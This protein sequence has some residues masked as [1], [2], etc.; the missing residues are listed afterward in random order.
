MINLNWNPIVFYKLYG[1]FGIQKADR[2]LYLDCDV[3][4]DDDLTDFY[5][6]DLGGYYGAVIEDVGME[7]VIPDYE[8]HLKRLM[9]KK[10][11]YFNGGVMLLNLKKIQ[12]EMCLQHMIDRFERYADLMPF[13]EQ[14]LLNM[15][16]NGR[17]CY[18]DSRY[19][20]MA[21]DFRYRRQIGKDRDVAIYHYTTNKPWT[22]WQNT[23]R[24][25]YGW[26]V[27]KYLQY[28]RL[29]ETKQLFLQVRRQNRGIGRRILWWLKGRM[30]YNPY[31]IY[32]GECA[33]AGFGSLFMTKGL[34]EKLEN[35][36][37]ELLCQKQFGSFFHALA[38]KGTCGAKAYFE[39]HKIR[40]IAVYGIGRVY[41]AV[42]GELAESADIRYFI[43]E[44]SAK[45]QINGKPVVS[46][47][48]L[49]QMEPVDG[50]VVTAV[51]FFHEIENGV[52]ETT[53]REKLIDM[54]DI[55]YFDQAK[56]PESRDI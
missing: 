6:M 24:E 42:N 34:T 37:R 50:I 41:Q 29:P 3:I 38:V 31:R 52:K 26:C 9:V 54:E 27:K 8:L 46:V 17:L 43:D 53:L 19:N 56:R 33:G 32:G 28:C 23:D 10:G 13:N 5:H 49:G 22:N 40:T 30:A 20:R 15:V 18:V 47:E 12:K 25:G 48:D 1:I 45:K 51:G 55:I 2:I 11:E 35:M 7:Q 14:D 39:A 44:R 21:S 4:V 16:W 36:E